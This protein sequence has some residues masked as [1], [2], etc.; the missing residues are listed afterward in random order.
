MNMPKTTPG[1]QPDGNSIAEKLYHSLRWEQF[2][3]MIEVV[4]PEISPEAQKEIFW[5]TVKE[6][7]L[8]GLDFS[9]SEL[10][11]EIEA[12][13]GEHA[14]VTQ[15]AE[16]VAEVLAPAVISFVQSFLESNTYKELKRKVKET[17]QLAKSHRRETNLA[18]FVLRELETSAEYSTDDL[19]KVLEAG[20]DSTGSTLDSPYSQIIDRAKAA[21]ANYIEAKNV[22]S[23]LEKVVDKDKESPPTQEDLPHITYSKRKIVKTVTD[24]F[25]N[26]FFSDPQPERVQLEDGNFVLPPLSYEAPNGKEEISL[27]YDFYF[28]DEALALPGISREFG[29]FDYFVATVL[30]NLFLRGNTR[31]S[32][33]KI[34]KELGFSEAGGNQSDTVVNS[35]IRGASTTIRIND[36]QVQKA[37]NISDRYKEVIDQVF[38]IRIINERFLAN[39]RIAEST[40]IIKD[41]TPFYRLADNIGHV[42]TWDKDI[43]QLYTG[44]KTARYWNILHYLIR[45]IGWMRNDTKRRRKIL[46]ESLYNLNGDKTTRTKQLTRDMLFRLLDEVFKPTGYVSAY[47]ED[48]RTNPGVSLSI[49]ANPSLTD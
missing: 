42:T 18:F 4:N 48:N 25:M 15:M 23:R 32:I 26:H 44:R 31:V 35:L 36:K 27:Y 9:L 39:G 8:F 46:Y 6:M 16:K 29:R 1:S 17:E 49:V 43:L 13:G 24:K 3:R 22:L 30:D 7:D 45:E 11:S 47:K 2:E 12:N 5:E 19:Q 33:Y 38:P 20:I 34:L 41:F 37:W 40:I 10:R 21:Q 14:V 28:N